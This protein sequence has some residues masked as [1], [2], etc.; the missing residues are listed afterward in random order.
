MK[1]PVHGLP[2]RA[3]VMAERARLRRRERWGRALTS[4]MS[5]LL[6]AAA[7]A[8]LLATRLLPVLRVYGSSMTPTLQDGEAVLCL[9]TGTPRQGDLVAFYYNNKILIKRVIAGAGQ[10]VDIGADGTVLVDGQPLEEPY[11]TEKSLGTCDIAFPYQVPDGRWFVLGDHRATSLDSR[12]QAVGCVSEE[13][14]IG[15]LSL[16]LW[17]LDRVSALK[18]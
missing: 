11:L 3:Q 1:P 5:I 7:A 2:S 12:V 16:R 14:L 17:P 18:S 8:V 6:V 13:Q 4:T 10:W 15:R 9:R